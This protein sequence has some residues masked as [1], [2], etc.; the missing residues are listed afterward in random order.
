MMN[1]TCVIR[2]GAAWQEGD[3]Q[4]ASTGR[5][6]DDR[7]DTAIL[8]AI[9]TAAARSTVRLRNPDLPPRRPC[10]LSRGGLSGFR[11]CCSVG[12]ITVFPPSG[13]FDF[14]IRQPACRPSQETTP[15]SFMPRAPEHIAP[16]QA[17]FRE[18]R[19]CEALAPVMRPGVEDY[20]KR[21][22]VAQ[23]R[24]AYEVNAKRPCLSL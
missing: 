5:S 1:T 15:A 16:S 3:A 17:P 6:H 13:S 11:P 19:D 4:G 21:S 20:R 14:P 18:P 2:H 9:T 8:V 22:T 12:A 7:A 10:R 23:E 24:I